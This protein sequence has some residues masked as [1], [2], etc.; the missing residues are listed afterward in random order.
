MLDISL[1]NVGYFIDDCWIQ[2]TA[3]LSDIFGQ[4]NKSNLKLHGKNMHIIH[5]RDNLQTF[6]SKL[7]D[8]RRKTNLVNYVV[9][10]HLCTAINCGESERGN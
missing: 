7:E 2:R 1:M 5:F 8:W 4:L 9:F 10:E 6:F 3:Y